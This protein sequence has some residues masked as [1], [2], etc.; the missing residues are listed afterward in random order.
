MDKELNDREAVL[1]MEMSLAKKKY[2]IARDNL[3]EAAVYKEKQAIVKALRDENLDI[4][5]YWE[6]SEKFK[7]M[8][9]TLPEYRWAEESD[10]YEGAMEKLY[11]AMEGHPGLVLTAKLLSYYTKQAMKH[12]EQY[13]KEYGERQAAWDAWNEAAKAMPEDQ[14]WT[15][16]HNAWI[17]VREEWRKARDE[18]ERKKWQE[19]EESRKAERGET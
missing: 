6:Y 8:K 5:R 4:Q 2:R 3:P 13:P 1:H 9:R 11:Q 16:A 10:F 12:P 18:D 17:A 7:R 14:A 15:D 19:Y